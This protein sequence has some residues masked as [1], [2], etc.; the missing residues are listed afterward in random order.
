MFSYIYIYTVPGM[1]FCASH[2][3]FM[4]THE[5]KEID[6]VGRNIRGTLFGLSQGS[7]FV[8]AG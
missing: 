4:V 5:H 8:A 1:C 3:F 7:R 6:A 2:G